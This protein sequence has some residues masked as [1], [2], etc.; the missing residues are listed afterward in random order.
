MI[1]FIQVF[2]IVL[3]LLPQVSNTLVWVNYELNIESITEEFCVNKEKPELKC[4][5]KCHLAEQ[6]EESSP[7]ESNEPAEASYI[8]QIPLFY[9]EIEETGLADSTPLEQNFKTF[10]FYSYQ[11]FLKIDHPPKA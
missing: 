3:F 7:V 1:R 2:V 4:N 6:L 11:P 9:Q 5:G 10:H 8:P